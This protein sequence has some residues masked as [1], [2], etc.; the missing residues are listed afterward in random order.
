M[1]S[2]FYWP[3]PLTDAF[4]VHMHACVY[5][6]ITSVKRHVT[7]HRKLFLHPF[8]YTGTTQ[9]EHR[10]RSLSYPS[11]HPLIHLPPLCST[12]LPPTTNHLLRPII[13]RSTSPLQLPWQ[14]LCWAQVPDLARGHRSAADHHTL[15]QDKPNKVIFRWRTDAV[16]DGFLGHKQEILFF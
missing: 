9:A 16:R 3:S 14:Q 15:P 2:S 11:S 6:P 7:L 13:T 12:S 8:T 1:F 4:K 10:L 5:P